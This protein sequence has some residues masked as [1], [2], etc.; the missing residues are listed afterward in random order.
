MVGCASVKTTAS[1]S[2]ALTYTEN[3]L[4]QILD[5]FIVGD[6]T[7]VEVRQGNRLK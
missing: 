2:E 6:S 3:K 7:S 5:G 4:P 1:S